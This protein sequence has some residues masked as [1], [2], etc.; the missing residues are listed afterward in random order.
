VKRG[1]KRLARSQ[2]GFTL[3]ELI[4]TSALG[5]LVLTGLTSVVLTSVRAGS[6]ATSRIEASG[7]IRNFEL[8]AY[9]EFAHAGVP[10]PNG[11]GTQINP[12][13]TQPIVL[14]GL[15]VTN[16]T[17]PVPAADSVSYTWDGAAFLDRRVGINAPTHV[18]T[19]VTA[20]SWYV[21]G[22]AP[23]PTVV[24]SLTVTVPLPGGTGPAAAFLGD[25]YSESQT[26]NFYPRVN[27]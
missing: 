27:P 24:V 4:I 23:H 1:L 20:F 9:D 18:A 14:A 10:T 15:Q 5:V 7:Q 22:A 2:E 19:N 3:I 12:C 8:R 6:V 16:S 11:C 13:T 17:P 25:P 26:L 21:T